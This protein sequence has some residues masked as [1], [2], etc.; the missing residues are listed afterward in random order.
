MARI[1]AWTFATYTKNASPLLAILRMPSRRRT[2]ID[3]AQFNFDPVDLAYIKNHDIFTDHNQ[4]FTGSFG[5]SYK[6]CN[7]WF[8]GPALREWMR[9]DGAVPNGRKLP[10]Y[11]P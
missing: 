6:W 1:M 5:V 3:S 7:R 2:N 4:T 10:A 11:S 9:A 8:S